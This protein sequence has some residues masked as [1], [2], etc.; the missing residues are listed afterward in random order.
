M[1][2]EIGTILKRRYKR[3]ENDCSVAIV[4]GEGDVRGWTK[5]LSLCE[6]RG[7]RIIRDASDR[8]LEGMYEVIG[9]TECIKGI[10]EFV[11]GLEDA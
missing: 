1:K 9:K 4:V 10:I 3:S 7:V 6:K 5:V 11:K 8:V 2:Y